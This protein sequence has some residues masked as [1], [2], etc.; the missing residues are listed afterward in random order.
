MSGASTACPDFEALSCFADGELI[1]SAAA[2]VAAHLRGCPRCDT[3]T[4]RLREGFAGGEAQPGGGVGGSGCIG[5]ERLVLYATGGLAGNDRAVIAA[6]VGGCDPC[7]AS[8]LQIHRRLGVLTSAAA[9]IPD[10]VVLRARAVLPVAMAEL[11]PPQRSRAA[12][13]R[14]RA[15]SVRERLRGWLQVPVLAPLAL[16]AM[17]V[18]AV[19]IGV[20]PSAEPAG[21]E[22]SRALPPAA[23]RLRVTADQTPLYSRPSGRSEVL[24]SVRRGTTVAVAGEERDWYE[25]RL[26]DGRSGWVAREAFE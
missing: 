5:E 13:S 23:V 18:L 17:A 26:D 11:A 7:I 24:A 15:L 14:E 19:A 8:L 6:H 16:A 20:R 21:V 4:R 25:V 2:G 10:E 12:A 22:R 9:A 3:L 1:A